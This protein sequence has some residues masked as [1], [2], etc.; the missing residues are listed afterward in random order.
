M[1]FKIAF[2][3]KV[4]GKKSNTVGLS[5]SCVFMFYDILVFHTTDDDHIKLCLVTKVALWPKGKKTLFLPYTSCL[6][7][8]SHLCM[9]A[10]FYQYYYAKD[11]NDVI[12]IHLHTNTQYIWWKGSHNLQP[13]IYK[14]KLRWFAYY[15]QIFQVLI[16]KWKFI[17]R[18]MYRMNSNHFYQYLE[19][20]WIVN[21]FMLTKITFPLTRFST[22]TIKMMI[23][24]HNKGVFG[25][26]V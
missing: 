21:C 4:D 12:S 13:W 15:Y 20:N 1:N 22:T 3:K 5:C 11:I 16:R 6:C 7:L 17:Q 8:P 9:F 19:N 26:W 24:N 25:Q 14:C 18:K 23:T 10:S 2:D